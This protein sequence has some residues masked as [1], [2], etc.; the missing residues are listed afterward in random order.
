MKTKNKYALLRIEL[1]TLVACGLIL[2]GGWH[3]IHAALLDEMLEGVSESLGEQIEKKDERLILGNFYTAERPDSHGPMGIMGEHTHNEG[4]FMATYRYANM[5]MKG[6]RSGTSDVSIAT[7]HNN[8][9][10]AP[11][12]RMMEM[13]MV[14]AMYGMNQTLTVMAMIPYI[15][16]SMDH[17]NRK[18]VKFRTK[19]SGMGDIK[20][21]T[22]WRLYAVEA[23]SIEAHRLHANFTVSIPTG[24]YGE[25]GVTPLG[26][27]RLPYPMQLGSGT[28]DLLP[29]ITYGGEMG[30]TSWA[31][32]ANATFHIARNKNDYSVGD[33]YQLTGFGAYRWADWIS[34]SARLDWRDWQNYDGKDPEIST[35][36][37]PTGDPNKRGGK[38]LDILGGMNI[39]FPEIMGL[40]NRLGIE[41]GMPIYQYLKGPQLETDII[42]WAGWQII[43]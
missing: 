1:A 23:P 39:L 28:V 9:V 4:E 2:Q 30:N 34:T 15:Q 22:L 3:A 40:E 5:F 16:K 7:V 19:T 12:D 43:Y 20:L 18:G 41:V 21:G 11:L 8:F 35:T 37:A 26:N 33:A 42:S 32:Q 25:E 31:L 13:H 36:T 10:V 38:R 29:S 17:V 24:A 14:S 6:N 27:I